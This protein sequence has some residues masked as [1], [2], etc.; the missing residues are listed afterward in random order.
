MSAKLSPRQAGRLG[1]MA[2]STTHA[3]AHYRRIGRK[4]GLA[5]AASHA[6]RPRT[7]EEFWETARGRRF[8]RRTAR[9]IGAEE[10]LAELL[11][12]TTQGRRRA[13]SP[14]APRPHS[15]ANR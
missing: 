5:A 15:G 1:G 9:S 8:L 10:V 14:A 13:A 6:E 11:P 2:T 4:G 12:S 3:R 7:P